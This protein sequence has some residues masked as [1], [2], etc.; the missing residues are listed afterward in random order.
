MHRPE[1]G[2]ESPEN[3]GPGR[4]SGRAEGVV[5]S[6]D[7]LIDGNAVSPN[8]ISN[9]KD[10]PSH[11]SQQSTTTNQRHRKLL[12]LLDEGPNRSSTVVQPAHAHMACFDNDKV[13]TAGNAFELRA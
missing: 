12:A 2:P 13:T 11:Q 7:A 8:T 4:F 6:E 9:N 1:K 10:E 5:Q 3:L